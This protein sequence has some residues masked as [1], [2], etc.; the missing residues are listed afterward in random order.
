MSD[1]ESILNPR[2]IKALDATTQN[3]W[4]PKEPREL[5]LPYMDQNPLEEESDIDKRR[6]KAKEVYDGY[7]ELIQ[8]SRKLKEEIANT[9]KDVSI[10]LKPSS[11]KAAMDA[12]KRVFGTDGTKITFQMYRTAIEKL[13]DLSNK[14][15]P[16]LGENK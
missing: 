13:S 15:V 2:D 10:T 1:I 6:K 14:A 11:E 3:N 8:S 4:I 7:G 9:C 5:L 12:V 16:T